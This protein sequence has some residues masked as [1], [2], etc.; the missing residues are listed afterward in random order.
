MAQHKTDPSKCDT[1]NGALSDGIEV[2]HRSDPA[3]FR[4][5]PGDPGTIPMGHRPSLARFP[6]V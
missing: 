5:G 3:D 6:L 2:N 4:S 1:D